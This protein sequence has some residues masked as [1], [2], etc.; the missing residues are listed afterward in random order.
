MNCREFLDSL[1][2]LDTSGTA[3]PGTAMRAHADS[4]PSCAA[5]AAS[6][7]AALSL[8]R[9]PELALSLDLAPRVSALLPF[10]P[11]P[12][13]VV[14]MRNWLGAGLVLVAGMVLLPLLSTF[15]AL[16]NAYGPGFTLPLAIVL[17][18]VITCY[19]VAFI[20][21]HQVDLARRLHLRQARPAA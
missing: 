21:S 11:A 20:F 15:G 16:R 1:D 4:C 3:E 12:R 18:L 17:G 13:R 9:L 5:A 7:R 19:A 14:S 8:C 2:R 10:L 6:M